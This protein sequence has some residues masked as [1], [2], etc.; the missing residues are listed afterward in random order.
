MQKKRRGKRS[1]KT[2]G[3]RGFCFTFYELARAGSRSKEKPARTKE[4]QGKMP[5]RVGGSSKEGALMK[6]TPALRIAVV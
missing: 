5:E 2:E 3:R 6:N 1:A 4:N